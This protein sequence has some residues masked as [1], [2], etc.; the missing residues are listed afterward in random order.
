MHEMDEK[1]QNF[2]DILKKSLTNISYTTWFSK[3]ELY[4]ITDNTLIIKSDSEFILNYIKNQYMELINESIIQAYNFPYEVELCIEEELQEIKNKKQKKTIEKEEVIDTN[5]NRVGTNLNPKLTFDNYIVGKTNQQA[6]LIGLQVAECPGNLY[7]P[8]FIYGKSGLGKTHL[9]NAI[10]NYIV[11]NSDKK[12]LYITSE[13]FI[14]DFLQYYRSDSHDD[15]KNK[16]LENFREKYQ[17]VDVLIIDD[18]QR[19]RKKEATQD[20]FKETFDKLHKMDKQIIIASDTSPNDLKEFEDRLKTRFA[21]GVIITIDPPDQDLKIKIL[22]NKIAGHEA[23]KKIKKEVLNYIAENSPNN[24][25]H[26]EGAINRL[27]ACMS[28][29]NP[30]IVDLEFAKESLKDT[31]GNDIYSY[32]SI[33]KIQKAV[34]DYYG[35]TVETLKSKKR[36]AE[37]NNPRQIAMYLCKIKTEETWEKIGLEFNKDHSTVIHGCNK[38][39]NELKTNPQ[40]KKEIKEITDKIS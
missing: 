12:V 7:N 40:L 28:M 3:L 35:I 22:E 6:Q 2:K 13:E 26:L 33:G 9:M 16:I 31:L 38:V 37:I 18:I 36:K 21:W 8:L 15:S 19:L 1:F 24:V 14:E 27:Y 11:E 20:E 39:E 30:E 5:V 34:A 17:N 25:R 10:G 32:N 29:F 4:D 23:A